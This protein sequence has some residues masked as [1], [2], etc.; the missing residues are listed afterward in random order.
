MTQVPRDC[1]NEIVSKIGAI[2]N[3]GTLFV[4]DENL[5]VVQV[6]E[7]VKHWLH[8][9]PELVLGTNL[10]RFLKPRQLEAL[11]EFGENNTDCPLVPVNVTFSGGEGKL[12]A[13]A[14]AH[15]SDGFLILELER[16]DRDTADSSAEVASEL[17]K[18]VEMLRTTGSTSAMLNTVAAAVKSIAGYDRVMIYKFHADL[19]GEV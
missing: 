18:A 6:S 5:N 16:V 17:K 19:H 12:L 10:D 11:M 9:L 4:A 3:F 13:N 15:K 8:L 1:D 14:V 2:Q 7:N